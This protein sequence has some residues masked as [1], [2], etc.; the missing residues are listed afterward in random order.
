[1]PDSRDLLTLEMMKILI[2]ESKKK[3]NTLNDPEKIRLAKKLKKISDKYEEQL[4]E[5]SY[6]LLTDCITLVEDLIEEKHEDIIK[7]GYKNLLKLYTGNIHAFVKT[8]SGIILQE[9]TNIYTGKCDN[10]KSVT[11]P[12]IRVLKPDQYNEKRVKELQEEKS[13]PKMKG[14]TIISGKMP[15]P[16][17]IKKMMEKLFIG[18]G[19]KGPGLKELA[20]QLGISE[21]ELK[22]YIKKNKG[23][24]NE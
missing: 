17:D 15:L 3:I 5:L 2:E 1:M 24:K 12:I 21:E 23:F 11:C 20:D 9:G 8:T 4:I 7:E 13:E 16:F 6:D 22:E 14:I 18:K 10:C 19:L